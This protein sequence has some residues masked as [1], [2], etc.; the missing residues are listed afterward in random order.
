MRLCIAIC[1]NQSIN[2]DKICQLIATLIILRSLQ[3]NFCNRFD[4]C[5]NFF[6]IVSISKLQKIA[7]YCSAIEK[8][9]PSVYT[10]LELG[11]TWVDAID[12]MTNTPIYSHAA[13]LKEILII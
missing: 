13:S 1:R 8:E 9:C 4:F 12:E 5:F 11:L 3:S 10:R 2:F 6:L 7:K